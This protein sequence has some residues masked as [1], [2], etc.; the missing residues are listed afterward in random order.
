MNVS[1]SLSY[2]NLPELL[3]S[4][5]HT[6]SAQSSPS[7]SSSPGKKKLNG[8]PERRQKKVGE[9]KCCGGFLA[10]RASSDGEIAGSLCEALTSVPQAISRYRASISAALH[11]LSAAL[12]H[13][14][15]ALCHIQFP[16]PDTSSPSTPSQRRIR[17]PQLLPPPRRGPRSL[18]PAVIC[19]MLRLQRPPP[20]LLPPPTANYCSLYS[21]CVFCLV[22][23]PPRF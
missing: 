8:N 12:N 2:S 4:A 17:P 22:R 15:A 20:A 19:G 5:S 6:H 11:G 10:D 7:S 9:K 13:N 16:L 21:R 23:R 1:L 3:W 14:C 18:L